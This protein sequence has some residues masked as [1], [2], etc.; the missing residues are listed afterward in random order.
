MSIAGK[1]RPFDFDISK[2]P[3]LPRPRGLLVTGAEAGVGKTLVAGAIARHLRGRG[4]RV[5][6]FKPAAAGCKRTREGLVSEEA[7]FLAACSDSRR[8]LEQIA[9]VRFR[10]SLAPNIAAE[11]MKKPLDLAAMFDAYRSLEGAADAVVVDG[12]GGLMC[13]LTDDF[14]MIHFARMAGL[15]VVIVVKAGAHAVSQA[16]LTLHAARSAGLSVAGV[17]LNRY[18]LEG[19]PDAPAG[20]DAETAGNV[21]AGADAYFTMVAGGQQIAQLGRTEVLAIVP[22][23][24]ENSVT[25]AT[26]GPNTQFAISQGPWERI[27]EFVVPP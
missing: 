19:E 22:E 14:W 17:V 27:V 9:P 20:D 1:D 12:V 15:P 21:L 7:E 26:I 5:E 6:V 13:P 11:R 4:I 3:L 10:R 24:A 16:L 23:E 8:T 25:R 2:H 18:R